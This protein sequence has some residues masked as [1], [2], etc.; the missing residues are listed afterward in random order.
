MGYNDQIDP[1]LR[2]TA[3]TV[4]FGKQI[5]RMGNI[6]QAAA[7]KLAKV[8]SDVSAK[9]VET[10]GYQ[11]LK[12]K[13]D[14][15]MPA[16]ASG[17]MPALIYVHGG[18]FCYKGAV[19]HKNLACIYAAKAKCKVFVPDYHLAPKYPYPAALEDVRS[20]YRYVADHAEEL[21][22]DP[23]RIGLA[24]DS[25]GATIA[26]LISNQY[27]RDGLAKPCLQM[28]V[29]PMTD[30]DM[31]TESMK[32]YTDTPFWNSQNHMQIWPLYFGDEDAGNFENGI[33][34]DDVKTEALP[35]YSIL[36]S[37]IPDTYIETTEF[38]CLHDE[39]ILYTQRL[40]EAGANV[41]INETKG[42]F[43]GYDMALDAQI[44]KD[45][46]KKRLS[47]LKRHF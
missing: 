28:L 31:Q 11:H 25:A 12:L 4:P 13:T 44:V 21:G 23:D 19:Y 40:R 42:T 2:K 15:F 27:E 29:Y 26:A 6:Y 43:H 1:E 20:L 22:I 16:G 38:D 46:V 39:G 36:P 5:V 3:R 14:I 37:S 47:F 34:K 10:E 8:P 17:P 30:N 32:K 33:L 7:W 41:E 9:T 18:A 24:G 45:A 35:M